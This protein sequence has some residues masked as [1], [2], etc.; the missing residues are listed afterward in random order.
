MI[1]EGSCKFTVAADGMSISWQHETDKICFAREHFKAHMHNDFSTSHNPVVAYGN[2]AQKMMGN[3]VAPDV[4]G[5]FCWAPQVNSFKARVMGAPKE[6]LLPYPT[7]HTAEWRGKQHLQF[8][9]LCHCRVQLVEQ[10]FTNMA[11]AKH[12]TIELLDI[13]SS[14]ERN[15]NPSS[16]PPKSVETIGAEA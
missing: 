8:N 5:Q 10:C 2:V 4:V 14:Q 15:N 3:K 1:P 13:A 7:R 12:R 16:P 6:L 11:K 9:T